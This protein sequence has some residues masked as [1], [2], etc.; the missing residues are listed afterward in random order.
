VRLFS[1][2]RAG[3]AGHAGDTVGTYICSDLG[4]SLL[5]RVAPYGSPWDP[6]PDAVVADRGAGLMRR[7]DAFTSRVL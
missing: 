5:I 6:N 4:C 7:L 2:L 1:A 3:D